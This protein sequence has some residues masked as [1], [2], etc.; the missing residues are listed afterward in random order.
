MLGFSG[1]CFSTKR[2]ALLVRFITVEF[3]RTALKE[4]RKLENRKRLKAV[5]RQLK[6]IGWPLREAQIEAI[7]TAEELVRR[8]EMHEECIEGVYPG[9]FEVPRRA[10]IWAVIYEGLQAWQRLT[11]KLGVDWQASSY[12]KFVT[13]WWR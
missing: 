3:D 6:P 5:E 11:E 12:H 1:N 2:K 7:K 9:S 4:R 10:G 8:I 13:K